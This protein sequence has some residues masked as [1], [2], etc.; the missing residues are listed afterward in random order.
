MTL[1]IPVT[2]HNLFCAPDLALRAMWESAPARAEGSIFE[3]HRHTAPNF[4][5]D[6]TETPPPPPALPP[7]RFSI[8]EA[9]ADNVSSAVS[10]T[11]PGFGFSKPQ[12][13]TGSSSSYQPAQDGAVSAKLGVVV[14]QAIYDGLHR[15]DGK[16]A[17]FDYQ[18]G[19]EFT[20]AATTY[21]NATASWKRGIPSTGREFVTK[22]VQLA[23]DDYLDSSDG[24]TY[25][26]LIEWMN[27]AYNRYL[28]TLQNTVPDLK[29]FK[30]AGGKLVHYHGEFV[31]AGSS[32]YYID[33]G[34]T[35]MYPQ[36][37]Y[38]QSVDALADWYRLFL[39]PRAAHCGTN[40]LQPGP[41]P[42]SLIDTLFE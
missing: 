5:S 8:N 32:I 9:I 6:L 26:T 30:N 12:V 16:W 14:A 19:S 41:W 2:V 28:D 11:S 29:T 35:S 15:S 31:P 18:I 24:V 4:F 33:N 38:N 1:V 40:S 25:D 34:R 10:S 27:I 21:H 37:I 20:D 22:F 39:I 17:Y 42:V 7:A 3:D 13:A 23:D 36:Q